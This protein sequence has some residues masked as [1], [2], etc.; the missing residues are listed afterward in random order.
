MV[1]V[2]TEPLM[3]WAMCQGGADPKWIAT[4]IQTEADAPL[5]GSVNGITQP[6]PAV[7]MKSTPQSQ[8]Q[9]ERGVMH[10]HN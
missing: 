10:K 2:G 4:V 6:D 3:R 9:Q 1:V 8:A 7:R 5:M